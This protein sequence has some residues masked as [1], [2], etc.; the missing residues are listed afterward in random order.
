MSEFFDLDRFWVETRQPYL[1]LADVKYFNV[2]NP[3]PWEQVP[4]WS[5]HQRVTPGGGNGNDGAFRA[6]GIDVDF[7]ALPE[8]RAGSEGWNIWFNEL[9]TFDLD[10]Q[11]QREWIQT[12]KDEILPQK[13]LGEDDTRVLEELSREERYQNLHD[14][15]DPLNTEPPDDRLLCLDTTL[16]IGSNIPPP[17]FSNRIPFEKPRSYEGEGW[18][19]AGQY[20][21]FTSE[22]EALADYYITEMFNV[23][24]MDQVPPLITVHVRRSDFAEARGLTSLDKYTDGVARVRRRLQARIDDPDSWM[25]AGKE[26][27][28]YFP[29]LTAND[30]AVVATSDEEPS[31]PFVQEL[32]SLGWKVL[33]HDRMQTSK[34]YNEWY[35]TIIDQAI[36][37]R[38]RGFV[39]TEWSTYSTLSGMRCK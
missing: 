26:N 20:L 39:G 16:F 25:G 29:G 7:W 13:P 31:S 35:P 5:V 18:A 28:V 2:T 1:E 3:P 23:T 30:Y 27:A 6:H 4:C 12:V 22:V 9:L 19:H 10:K 11:G 14:H 36:L 37:A 21:H 8:M 38:G 32:V 17:A 34:K 33:D 24:S 15:F